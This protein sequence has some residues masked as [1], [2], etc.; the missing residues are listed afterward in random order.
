M[1]G[2]PSS[3]TKGLGMWQVRGLSRMPSPPAM[4]IACK[5]KLPS[6]LQFVLC[7]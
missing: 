5:D 3:G 1:T 4:M 6:P 2:S 7:A